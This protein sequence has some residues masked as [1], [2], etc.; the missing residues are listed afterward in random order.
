M[1]REKKYYVVTSRKLVRPE[2]YPRIPENWFTLNKYEDNF[3][4]RVRLYPSELQ[5]LLA[6]EHMEVGD[7]F[8]VYE[9]KYSGEVIEPGP[10][11]V[12]SSTIT[13]EVWV[14]KPIMLTLKNEISIVGF[15]N[16]YEE[17]YVH[18]KGKDF[19]VPVKVPIYMTEE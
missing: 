17:F 5:A 18:I 4:P 1:S 6:K 11:S 12:P 10:V 7:I 16:K 9:F 19:K 13:G 8:Y 3:T 14:K 2:L 15:E